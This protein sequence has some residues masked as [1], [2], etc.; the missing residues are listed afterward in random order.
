ML[1]A[2]ADQAL[3]DALEQGQLTAIRNGADTPSTS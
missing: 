1:V 3:L 2:R